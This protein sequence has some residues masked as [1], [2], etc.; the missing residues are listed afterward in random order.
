MFFK[1]ED[2]LAIHTVSRAA[3]RVL[4]DLTG[5]SDVKKALTAHIEKVGA[6]RFNEETNFLKHADQDPGGALVSF[7]LAEADR[8]T[9]GRAASQSPKNIT[10]LEKTEWPG[11]GCPGDQ[12]ER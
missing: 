11:E 12:A 6:Q 1:N 2:M 3:F 8:L 4:Y 5:E 9:A 10:L 7:E